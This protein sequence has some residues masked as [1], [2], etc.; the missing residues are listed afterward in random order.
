[1]YAQHT[2]SHPEERGVLGLEQSQ[3]PLALSTRVASCSCEEM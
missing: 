3:E 1:M 2:Q